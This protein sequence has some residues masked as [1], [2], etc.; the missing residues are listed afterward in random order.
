MLKIIGNGDITC[1]NSFTIIRVNL[2]HN[3]I[4]IHFRK[5]SKILILQ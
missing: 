3:N 5:N 4:H 2:Q 1:N